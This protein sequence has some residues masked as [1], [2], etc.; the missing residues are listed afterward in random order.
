[1]AFRDDYFRHILEQLEESGEER[2]AEDRRGE[3]P[4]NLER[5]DCDLAEYHRTR[6]QLLHMTLDGAVLSG[7]R[8]VSDRLDELY[9]LRTALC[10]HLEGS[11]LGEETVFSLMRS[12][13]V[14]TQEQIA[15]RRE[16]DRPSD[17]LAH[18]LRQE[19]T[20][21]M[22]TRRQIVEAWRVLFELE[23]DRG[24]WASA[25]DYLFHAVRLSKGAGELVERGLDFYQRLLELSDE[26][27]RKGGL[28]RQEADRARWDLL[29]LQDR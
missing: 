22:L 20:A 17:L 21:H 10:R 15:R 23:A 24:N 5:I 27:I 6:P 8:P 13:Y 7:D 1:M 11:E 18:I 16:P 29:E 28:T 4:D 3:L 12:I 14:G 26:E 25:E 2:V 19:R 9:S